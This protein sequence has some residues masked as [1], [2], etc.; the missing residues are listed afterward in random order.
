MQIVFHIWDTLQKRF[1]AIDEYFEALETRFFSLAEAVMRKQNLP[2]R[3]KYR[4]KIWKSLQQIE[5][6]MA[7][8]NKLPHH[9]FIQ[10]ICSKY[11]FKYSM[12]ILEAIPSFWLQKRWWGSGTSWRSWRCWGRTRRGG[13]KSWW[14]KKWKYKKVE[15]VENLNEKVREA[16]SHFNRASVYKKKIEEEG[17]RVRSFNSHLPSRQFSTISIQNKFSWLF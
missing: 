14:V 1:D 3:P 9:I 5:A 15:K 7:K 10:N 8:C 13:E 2:P 17:N 11:S 12:N 4:W 16:N 6:V